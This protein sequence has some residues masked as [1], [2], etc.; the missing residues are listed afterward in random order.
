MDLKIMAHLVAGFPGREGFRQA[1]RGLKEGGA[2]ILEL[3]I[4][5]SDPTADGPV[6]TAACEDAIRQGFKVGQIFDYIQEARKA[7]FDRIIVMTYANIA[8]RYGMERYVRDLRYAGVEAALVP[9]LPLEDEEGFYALAF[10]CGLTPMPVV[11]VNMMPQRREL[12]KK[13]PFHKIYISIR[14]GITGRETEITPQVK[15]FLDDLKDY[16]RFAGFG[17]RSSAQ[18]RALAPHADVAVVGSYFTGV[19]QEVAHRN[20]DIQRAVREAM[21]TLRSS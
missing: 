6:I 13:H 16:Q 20:G 11:V 4:P 17:I 2:D 18:I 19:I 7:G 21:T 15:I 3:Q 14:A 9:D 8:F 5:F 12:L 10:E 1:V